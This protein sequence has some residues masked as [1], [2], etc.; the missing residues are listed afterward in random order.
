MKT[1]F[2]KLNFRILSLFFKYFHII[3]T[4]KLLWHQFFGNKI[5]ES[6]QDFGNFQKYIRI[7]EN[8]PPYNI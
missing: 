2:Q 8:F 1:V 5:S 3:S 4:D 6:E 7:S